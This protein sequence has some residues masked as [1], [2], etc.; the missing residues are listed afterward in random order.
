MLGA[1]TTTTGWK[2]ATVVNDDNDDDNADDAASIP[3]F[4]MQNITS[5]SC[6][7]ATTTWAILSCT[8]CPIT[9]PPQPHP[10]SSPHHHPE[11]HMP[12][13]TNTS[14]ISPWKMCL[15]TLV[16]PHPRINLFP[17]IIWYF[18][19]T[20]LEW[21]IFEWIPKDLTFKQGAIFQS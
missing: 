4:Y 16:L 21:E 6:N 1:A 9:F 3:I 11:H 10:P 13:A 7:I 19:L 20:L 8:I 12:S 14:A 5:L 15:V 17:I 2:K 18:P